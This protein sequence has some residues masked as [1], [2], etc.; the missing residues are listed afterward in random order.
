MRRSIIRRQ[1]DTAQVFH[2]H[3]ASAVRHALVWTA[4]T[5]PTL[6]VWSAVD[7]PALGTGGLQEVRRLSF[8]SVLR[9]G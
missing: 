7:H 6:S 1:R 2:S 4:S 9:Y 3:Q 8:P 5:F